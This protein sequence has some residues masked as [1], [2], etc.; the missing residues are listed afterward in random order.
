MS[1]K[2]KMKLIQ[3]SEDLQER[4]SRQVK[5]LETNESAIF[6]QALV[7]FLEEQEGEENVTSRG[8]QRSA[9]R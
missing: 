7:K 3:I 4:L 6:R 5:R 1:K 2:G 8:R 9:H